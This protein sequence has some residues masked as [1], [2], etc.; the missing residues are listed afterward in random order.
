VEEEAKLLPA[1]GANQHA[2]GVDVALDGNTAVISAATDDRLTLK[3]VARGHATPR[4]VAGRELRDRLRG[5]GGLIA[6]TSK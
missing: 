1:G 3:Q 4:G 2:F 6:K 5:L